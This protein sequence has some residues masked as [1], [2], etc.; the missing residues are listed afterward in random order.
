MA[1]VQ[2]DGA[3]SAFCARCGALFRSKGINKKP[4]TQ[5]DHGF[6]VKMPKKVEDSEQNKR[7]ADS[8]YENTYKPMIEHWFSQPDD[9]VSDHA[10]APLDEESCIHLMKCI[11]NGCK[12]LGRG[13]FS[14]RCDEEPPADKDEATV[15]NFYATHLKE[16]GRKFKMLSLFLTE[17]KTEHEACMAFLLYKDTSKGIPTHNILIVR[18]K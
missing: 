2:L 4:H 8:K 5:G 11:E 10:L 14:I 15:W 9:E 7:I 13:A 16:H 17:W 3:R 1:Q 12:S 18:R 6:F